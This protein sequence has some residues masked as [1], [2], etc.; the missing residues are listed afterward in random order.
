[1]LLSY[2][3]KFMQDVE[4]I[5]QVMYSTQPEIE[6][7]NKNIENIL[8]DFFV[9]DTSVEGIKHYE[10]IVQI[11]PK[12]TDSLEKRK[13]DILAIYNQILPFTLEGLKEKLN[14]IC[15]EDGYTIDMIYD[16]FILNVRISLEKKEL[17]LTV[18][19]LLEMIVPVNLI[20]NFNIDYNIWKDLNK[21]TWRRLNSIKWKDVKED[22]GIKKL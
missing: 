21:V 14:V 17:F 13:Y 22:K 16:K 9:L 8:K 19:N 1:M 4:E 3:P 11:I 2:L 6:N 5:Q 20:I 12:L 10:K 15:G 18:N 7:I